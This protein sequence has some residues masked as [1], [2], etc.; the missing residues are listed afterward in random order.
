MR[1]KT[2]SVTLEEMA[3]D[4]EYFLVLVKVGETF[5]LLSTVHKFDICR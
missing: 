4:F 3:I 5:S 1:Q 2:A